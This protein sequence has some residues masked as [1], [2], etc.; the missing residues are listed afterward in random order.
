MTT[1]AKKETNSVYIGAKPFMK[2]VTAAVLKM[3]ALPEV[4]IKARG[5]WISRAVD[6]SEVIKNSFVRDSEVKNIKI[7]SET[8]KDKNKKQRIS[9]MEITLGK[10]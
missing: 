7:G 5:K 6:V 10:K 3:N 8:F 2:Y 9:T 4:I 1:N